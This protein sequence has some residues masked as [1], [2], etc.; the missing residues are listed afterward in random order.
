MKMYTKDELSKILAAHK[1][2]ADTG[3][4]E[5]EQ[6]NLHHADLRNADLRDADLRCADLRYANLRYANLRYANLRCA[7]LR[8]ADL[9]NADLDFSCGFT[10]SCSGSCFTASVKLVYQY[11]AHLCTISA[12]EDE[13]EEMQKIKDAIL[14]FAKKSHRAK[15]LGLLVDDTM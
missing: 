12:E 6:A 1:V 13:K 14:P 15:D 8:D 4:N 2:W 9:R 3:G 10:L 7:D 5:G 11:L